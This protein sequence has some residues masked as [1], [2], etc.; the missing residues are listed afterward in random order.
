MNFN[1]QIPVLVLYHHAGFGGRKTVFLCGVGASH[2]ATTSGMHCQFNTTQRI[3][4]FKHLSTQVIYHPV[5]TLLGRSPRPSH[6]MQQKMMHS[7]SD[8]HPSS[9]ALTH[10]PSDSLSLSNPVACIHKVFFGQQ[11][12]T[13]ADERVL[14]SVRACGRACRSASSWGSASYMFTAQQAHDLCSRVLWPV[15]AA[16]TTSS[17]AAWRSRIPSCERMALMRLSTAS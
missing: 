1:D 8:I 15:S 3:P 5:T 16:V 7:F 4:Q 10:R 9:T 12:Q 11:V 2:T 13:R 17:G 6:A 14:C